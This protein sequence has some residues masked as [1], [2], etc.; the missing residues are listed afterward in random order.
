[1]A[2]FKKK[3]KD[4]LDSSVDPKEGQQSVVMK[5]IKNKFFIPAVAVVVLLILVV[6]L[7]KVMNS[8]KSDMNY[9][10]TMTSIF[11]NELGS[12]NYT[13]SVETGEKGSVIKEAIIL[14][15]EVSGADSDAEFSDGG[16]GREFVSW[17]K[18]AE[19]KV[20]NWK[21][22]V[23]QVNISGTTMS[24]D[25]LQTMF[26]VSVA[27]PNYNNKFT[28]VVATDDTYYF[29]VESIYNWLSESKDAYLVNIS[30]EIPRGSK[31][32]EIP[33]SEFAIPSWYAEYGDEEEL[34]AAHSITTMYRRFLSALKVVTGSINNS[35][36]S[37]GVTTKADVVMLN[38]TGDD[39]AALANA[40]KSL[41][42]RS[43]DL[44]DSII[45]RRM[46]DNLYNESQK[47][48]ADREK[49]NFLV[50]MSDFATAVQIMKPSDLGVQA[51]GQVRQ[52]TNG[53]GNTQ[54]EGT[55]GVQF[56]TDSA[57]Y[58]IKFQGVRNGNQ[59]QIAVPEGSKTRE[60]S[61]MYLPAVN[62]IIEYFNF[63]PIKTSVKLNITPDVITETVYEKFIQLVN[64]VGTAGY[65]LTREN[66]SEFIE[67]YYDY[68]DDDA[69]T[70]DDI[71][72]ARM[73]RDLV[74]AMSAVVP[75]DTSG[76]GVVGG[77]EIPPE[78]YVEQYPDV[79]WEHEGAEYTFK[80]RDDLS[81]HG[82][83][84]VD[85][86]VINK[87]GE[88]VTIDLT[89]FSMHD[90]LSSI[91]PANNTTLIRGHDST[92]DMTKLESSITI[93]ASGWKQFKMYFV[94]VDDVG[95]TDLFFGDTQLGA[96][97]QY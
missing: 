20:S 21:Y 15:E 58:V 39:A 56:S 41:G 45:N 95:H 34:S 3:V 22:P 23:Y 18:Y 87:A 11:S 77:S 65:T 81:E 42:T 50:A 61:E 93:P 28:E 30:K 86:D 96:I 17:D 40:V 13:F 54:I 97:I 60:N 7:V 25:P 88:D 26:T 47:K 37:R 44:Y 12:F 33:A 49:D 8:D 89:E 35:M 36:G 38:L 10:D 57:D 76:G 4:E 16:S 59:K 27:T 85:A 70:A 48:Q 53:Y 82:L 46:S 64:D 90:L 71:V 69:E 79:V 74:D 24:V 5:V 94:A 92:F 68:N 80:Y 29:D 73:V 32:L 9:Y 91:Y 31:W 19:V 72:N 75:L 6:T 67:K 78:V 2:L 52:Y 1:M 43:G 63:T 14:P 66:V 55:F 84:V 51:A 62:K 83:F